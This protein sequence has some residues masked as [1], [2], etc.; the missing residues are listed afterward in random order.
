MPSQNRKVESQEKPTT[1]ATLQPPTRGMRPL[2][3]DAQPQ[4]SAGTHLKKQAQWIRPQ[5]TRFD[6]FT[7]Y[8]CQD[9]LE[10]PP[11]L[12][13]KDRKQSSRAPPA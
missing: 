3:K 11:S 7:T 9:P 8:Q 12:L 6:A 1:I 10:E 4:R 13:R 5:R 2:N